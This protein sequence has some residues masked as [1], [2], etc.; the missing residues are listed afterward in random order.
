[1]NLKG[2]HIL[3]TGASKGIGYAIADYLLVHGAKVGVHYHSGKTQAN[4]LVGKYGKER[5]IA[6]HADLSN[7]DEVLLLF[8]KAV[9]FLGKID[10]IILNAGVFIPHPIELGF[11]D[12]YRVWKQTLAVN[13]DA[14]GI[15]TKV[16]LDHF[17]PNKSG[18]IIYI[19]SRAAFRGETEEYL[20]YAASKG[21]LTSLA[22]SV[23]RSFGKYNVKAFVIAPGFTRTAM[24]EQFI[25]EYGE[26]K[27]L[28]EIALNTLTEVS[29][30]APL[31]GFMSTGA[32]DH[33]TGTTIDINAGSYI[34]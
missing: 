3:V 7:S 21:G 32:M 16:G 33:A 19:G 28:D 15:L 26:A 30:I 29:D 24:A 5:A 8:E 10:T 18:R 4:L 13:L 11:N 25:S 12:W 20:A 34:H 6:L 27:V 31:V 22:R 17:I 2:Q 9:D 1:M 14:V 23:A